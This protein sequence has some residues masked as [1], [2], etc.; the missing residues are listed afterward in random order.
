MTEVIFSLVKHIVYTRSPARVF[1]QISIKLLFYATF[2]S[3]FT[4]VQ[5]NLEAIF[6]LVKTLRTAA[7]VKSLQIAATE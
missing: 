3:F 6:S 1:Q 7:P 5:R 2:S 4:Y